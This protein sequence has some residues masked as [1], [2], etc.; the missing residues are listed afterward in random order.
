MHVSPVALDCNWRMRGVP[1]L[2]KKHAQLLL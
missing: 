1:C 2:Y